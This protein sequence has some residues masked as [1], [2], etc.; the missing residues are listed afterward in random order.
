MQPGTESREYS[1]TQVEDLGSALA[2][3]GPR[4]ELGGI[5]TKSHVCRLETFLGE[6]AAHGSNG[7]LLPNRETK[8]RRCWTQGC[9]WRGLTHV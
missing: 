8:V 6:D 3:R 7:I 5:P 4:T 1:A 9:K 2:L